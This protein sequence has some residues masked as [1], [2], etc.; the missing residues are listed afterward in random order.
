MRTKFTKREVAQIGDLQDQLIEV[1]NKMEKRNCELHYG[2]GSVAEQLDCAV[3]ALEAILQE[4]TD[5][6]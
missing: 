5:H 6:E 1:R 4:F 3:T 2:N